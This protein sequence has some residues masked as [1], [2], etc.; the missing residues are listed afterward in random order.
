MKRGSTNHEQLRGNSGELEYLILLKY[1]M[2]LYILRKLA[3][4]FDSLLFFLVEVSHWGISLKK[5]TDATVSRNTANNI[6][7]QPDYFL[8]F[9]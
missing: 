8:S 5:N 1:R 6:S 4:S 3:D 7:K 9:F 2:V